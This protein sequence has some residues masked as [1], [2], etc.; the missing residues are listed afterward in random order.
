MRCSPSYAM[1]FQPLSLTDPGVR[2]PTFMAG[3]GWVV[4][5]GAQANAISRRTANLFMARDSMGMLNVKCC[6]LNE[7]RLCPRPHA[8][9][10]IQHSPF[11]DTRA[12]KPEGAMDD[13]ERNDNG[14]EDDDQFEQMII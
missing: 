11:C 6:M 13:I 7:I 5:R 2:S 1:A 4:S 3:V 14:A 12:A 8:T 9:C 10:N